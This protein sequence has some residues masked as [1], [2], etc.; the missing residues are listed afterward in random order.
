MHQLYDNY[1]PQRTWQAAEDYYIYEQWERSSSRLVDIQNERPVIMMVAL[2]I[3]LVPELKRGN[4][5]KV[6]NQGLYVGIDV[7]VGSI[8]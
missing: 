6:R 2:C 1:D 8:R 7:H 3:L 4:E 5:V